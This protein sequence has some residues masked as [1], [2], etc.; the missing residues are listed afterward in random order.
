[1]AKPKSKISNLQSP[2][3]DSRGHL[4]FVTGIILLAFLL[5]LAPLGH[6]VTPDEPA[7]VY[8]S[9]RFADALAA[10]D[11]AAIPSTGHPGV[12]TMWLGALS[13]SIQRLLQPAESVAHLD[14]I[15]R[16][17]WLDPE[18]GEAFHHL[19]FFLPGGRIVVALIT[20]LGLAALYPLLTRI[21]DHRLALL[22]VGLL[23]FDP[24]LIGHSGL[25]HTDAL[26][27]TFTLLALVAALNGLREPRRSVWWALSGLFT[28]LALLT[29]TPAIILIPSIL[30]LRVASLTGKRQVASGKPTIDRCSLVIAHW[31]LFILTTAATCLA[32][33]P[34]LRV[35]PAKTS[36]TLFTFSERHVEMA[37]RP[38]FFAGQMTY[39][40]GPLFYPAVLLFRASPIV[41]VGL[42]VGLIALRQLP[43]DR[44]FAFLALIA[45]SIGFGALMSLGVKKHDRYLLPALPPLT[46][47]A[48]LGLGAMVR[49]TKYPSTRLSIH[50]S[51]ISNSPI[52]PQALIAFAFILHPL[53]YANPLAGGPWIARRVLDLDWG[54]AMG[55]AAR[56]LNRQPDAQQLTVAAGSVPTF[57]SLFKGYTVPFAQASVANYIVSPPGDP[58]DAVIYTRP[59]T[60]PDH[61]TI[62]TNI[63]PTAQ[64]TYLANHTKPD[65]LIL[66][67]ADTPLLRQYAGLGTLVSLADLPTPAAVAERLHELI[68][69]HSRIWLVADPAASPFAAAYVRQSVEAVAL[70]VQ[71]ELIGSAEITQFR[72]HRASISNLQSPIS[73]FGQITLLDASISAGPINAPFEVLLRWQV[74]SPTPTNLHFSLY[75]VDADGHLWDDAGQLVLNDFT[76]P[77]TNWEPDEWSDQSL[78]LK[79]PDRIPPGTYSVK[80]TVTDGTGAQLGAW[81]AGGAFQGVRVV[82]GEVEIAPPAKPVGRVGCMQGRETIAGPLVACLA[83]S[84]PQAVP[85]GDAFTVAIVWSTTSLPKRN[86]ASRWR[87]LDVADSVAMEKTLPLSSYATS[88]WRQDDSFDA[89]YTLHTDP[90]IPAGD[91]ILALNVIDPDGNPLWA[92]DEIIGTI[93]ILLRARQFDLPGDIDHPLNL[94]LGNTIHLRGFDLDA[95]TGAPGDALP[96]T[97]YW[98]G[99]GPTDIDYTVFVHLTG[100]DGLPHG[101]LDVSPGGGSAPTSSWAPGQVVVDELVLPIDTD[102]A[103]GTYHIAVGLYDAASGGR[104]PVTDDFGQ[105]PPDDRFILPI[106]IAVGGSP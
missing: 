56:W 37:Q 79:S 98:Q 25:L 67:D 68:D 54:E 62:E 83:E 60:F 41:L 73:N 4:P 102:A 15:G 88:N 85:S 78:M 16:M 76:F 93:E 106:E 69:D 95:T 11:W 26:L 59:F 13:V 23:A 82:L 40:P 91:Y 96:L 14:W 45:F 74:S 39:N 1:M 52:L 71:A 86:Y 32:L 22:A 49:F 20:T 92:E 5:R 35:N 101:Q 19:A 8:R 30:V 55:A 34:A 50:Q 2:I 9:I 103:P 64:A 58:A 105:R 3:S 97:L 66:L 87:L 51:L 38:I 28:G 12:T 10:R 24:F 65:D 53:T 7:W 6:Y 99:D 47:A 21:F 44:R 77:T 89:R 43:A 17:A 94:T 27:A 33:Y 46:L 80:L 100:P 31:S 70:P 84:P 42:L 36:D 75:L 81:D 61:V 18:N 104:L 63:D 48:T 72:I 90:A 29:K 57:A